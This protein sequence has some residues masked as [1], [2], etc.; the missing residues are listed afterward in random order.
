[1]Q[2]PE[3]KAYQYFCQ[4]A[5]LINLNLSEFE[6]HLR[7][8]PSQPI[9]FYASWSSQFPDLK[10]VLPNEPLDEAIGKAS[11]VVGI[12]SFALF[13]SA[14]AKKTTIS[15]IPSWAQPCPIPHQDII[16]L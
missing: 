13:L 14:Q 5:P 15:A 3:F 2:I 8:H 10:I 16:H 9:D 7:L 12:Y 1:M 6:V 11:V 4:K